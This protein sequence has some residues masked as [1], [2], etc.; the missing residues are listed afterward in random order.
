MTYPILLPRADLAVLKAR[1]SGE[2]VAGAAVEYLISV[3]NNGPSTILSFALLDTTALALIGAPFGAPSMG[4]SHT[5]TGAWTG[6]LPDGVID[7]DP[8]NTISTMT[9]EIDGV[10]DLTAT[11]IGDQ[12]YTSG[13]LLNFTV[14]VTNQGPTFAAGVRVVDTLPV[15]VVNWSWTVSYPGLGS[16]TA[17]G[18]PDSA[19]DGT[20]G[21][22]KLMNLAVL[23]TATF[24]ITALTDAV[25]QSDIT[26]TVVATIG[27]EAA[28]ANWSSA[29]DGPINP[30]ADVGSLVVSNDDLCFGLPCVRVLDPTTGAVR[31][32]LLAYGPSFRGPVRVATGDLTGDGVNEIIASRASGPSR[33]SVFGVDP[34]A[35]DPMT[36]GPIRTFASNPH[37][38]VIM[39][40]IS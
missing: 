30:T 23:G 24:T 2:P 3:T 38:L 4:S 20:A 25:F 32:Q 29:H 39:G 19:T 26:N 36:N 1:T 10:I 37:A 5:G 12:T 9:D 18:S 31:S 34:L 40:I 22:D 35:A 14:V 13:G 33:V 6:L 11:K 8:S 21:I 17:G 27:E 28:T 15:G 16:G 7:P